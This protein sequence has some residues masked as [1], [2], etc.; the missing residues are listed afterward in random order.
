MHAQQPQDVAAPVSPFKDDPAFHQPKDILAHGR[1]RTL[2]IGKTR[3]VLGSPP[4]EKSLNQVATCLGYFPIR[5]KPP[6]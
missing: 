3:F 2:C 1:C 6:G 4:A 5:S